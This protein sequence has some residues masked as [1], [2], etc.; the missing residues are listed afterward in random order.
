M[1]PQIRQEGDHIDG[2]VGEFIDIDL[3]V[4]LK[5]IVVGPS[6]YVIDEERLDVG[7]LDARIRVP[8]FYGS[9]SECFRCRWDGEIDLLSLNSCVDL[10]NIHY[11]PEA[12]VSRCMAVVRQIWDQEAGEDPL[13]VERPTESS[14][15]HCPQIIHQGSQFLS[16]TEF[17]LPFLNS[18]VKTGDKKPKL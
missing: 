4:Q 15:K 2:S 1:G 3:L 9:D 6:G 8:N 10:I 12:C 18:R 13:S 11:S 14:G 5:A 16:V 7:P 17:A